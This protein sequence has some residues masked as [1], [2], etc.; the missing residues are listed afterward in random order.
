MVKLVRGQ[1]TVS[2]RAINVANAQPTIKGWLL[3]IRSSPAVR[4]AQ[5]I[6]VRSIS[7]KVPLGV[8]SSAGMTATVQIDD[9]SRTSRQ[10][11]ADAKGYAVSQGV[12]MPVQTASVKKP[13][14][15][16]DRKNE[17]RSVRHLTGNRAQWRLKMH[18]LPPQVELRLKL[19]NSYSGRRLAIGF[20]PVAYWIDCS[21]LDLR[22]LI[23]RNAPLARQFLVRGN[24]GETMSF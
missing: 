18:L 4:L 14:R 23:A 3:S 5:R 22:Q 19:V 21:P 11:S 24:K 1:S 13:V 12:I 2:P 16:V 20:L 10:I 7:M 17:R 9:R 8:R 15:I 6:P